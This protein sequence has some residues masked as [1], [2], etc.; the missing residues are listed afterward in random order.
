MDKYKS[1][2]E[3]IYYGNRL[4]LIYHIGKSKKKYVKMNGKFVHVH[5]NQLL[6]KGGVNTPPSPYISDDSDSVLSGES[7][8]RHQYN[9]RSSEST[10]SPSSQ[11]EYSS[12]S[13]ESTLSPSS[14]S[15]YSSRS[16]RSSRSI[17]RSINN[18]PQSPNRH[19]LFEK[20]DQVD[21]NV[22]TDNKMMQRA[23]EQLIKAE[24]EKLNKRYS[25]EDAKHFLKE[26]IRKL[27]EMMQKQE[28]KIRDANKRYDPM[29]V[30][31]KQN[32]DKYQ[33]NFKTHK[34]KE[35]EKIA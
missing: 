33:F 26:Y 25:K 12:R 27:P 24:E 17:S 16:S 22:S 1:S 9:P 6:K 7:T 30:E 28:Q 29:V 2:G 5:G 11:S 15:E 35:K 4:R 10:L 18:S 21:L 31:W 32:P 34:E 8:V 19:N 3:K 23:M 14:Q 20:H 13:S